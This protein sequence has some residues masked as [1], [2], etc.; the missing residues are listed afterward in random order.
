MKKLMMTTAIVAMT[1]MG[2]VAQT[3]DTTT[4]ATAQAGAEAGAMGQ[5]VPAFVVS[6]F[7]G[8]NLYTLQS[9]AAMNLRG[10]GTQANQNMRW[11]S[12]ATFTGERD[13]WENV[14]NITDVVMSKDGEVRGVLI[15][16]GGFLGLGARTVMVDINELYFVADDT[17]GGTG[18]GTAADGDIDDFSVVAAMTEEQL[19]ALPEWDE[20]RLNEGFESR[21]AV[22]NASMTTPTGGTTAVGTETETGQTQTGQTQTDQT[23]TGQ[24]QTGAAAP[25]DGMAGTPEGY[26]QMSPEDRTAERLI[27]ANAYGAQGE[28]IATVDDL[29]LDAD[30]AATHV[31]MDV[32]GF[33]GMG[34]HTVAIEIDQVDI[35]WNDQDG[36]VMVQVPMTEDQ[37]R[38]MPEYEG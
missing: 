31:I 29:V 14:G 27:G 5:N 35:L 25:A 10:D 12:G 18:T 28:D 30:G 3:A 38:E 8:K 9:E 23:Q 2:A 6:N 15:D 19:E 32:G 17:A 37:L 33:L 1:S 13:S 21:R 22:D 36:D 11:E 4:D 20:N 7:T 24:A 34:T 26:T 16:V